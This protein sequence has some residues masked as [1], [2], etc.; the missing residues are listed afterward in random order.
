M[1][2]A[3]IAVAMSSAGF[4]RAGDVLPAIRVSVVS[5]FDC[6]AALFI[7]FLSAVDRMI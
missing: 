3:R 6:E 5:C 4:T 1:M 2:V 7:V